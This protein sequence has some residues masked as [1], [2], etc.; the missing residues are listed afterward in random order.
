MN[1]LKIF[2]VYFRKVHLFAFP[3]KL[4][5]TVFAFKILFIITDLTDDS[6]NWQFHLL[7]RLVVLLNMSFPFP[8]FLCVNC[9]VGYLTLFM[10]LWWWRTGNPGVLQSMGSQSIRHSLATEQ[11]QMIQI[12]FA[13]QIALWVSIFI[14]YNWSRV[15]L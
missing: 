6:C 1:I 4:H 9:M 8:S 7:L 13:S 12:F 10:Y 14:I 11:Q 2:S 5:T 3:L 15:D